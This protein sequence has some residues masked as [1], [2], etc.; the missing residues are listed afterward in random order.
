ML[1]N[2]P[3]AGLSAFP[4]PTAAPALEFNR[5]A[6][7]VMASVVVIPMTKLRI[8]FSL[9]NIQTQRNVEVGT[10]VQSLSMMLR[11]ESI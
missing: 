2:S 7:A 11:A 6:L 10:L 3:T 1:L 5:A 8:V 9:S 4:A